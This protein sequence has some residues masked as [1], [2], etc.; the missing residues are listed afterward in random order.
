MKSDSELK[1]DVENELK[2]DPR[3]NQPHIG[4]SSKDGLITLSGH[5]T[6]YAEKSAAVKAANRVY[7]VKAV[8]DEIDVKLFGSP[9]HTDEDIAMACINALKSHYAVP[10]EKIKSYVGRRSRMEPPEAGCRVCYPAWN[11]RNHQ[12]NSNQATRLTRRH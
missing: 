9:N 5:V 10:D 2:W 6:A 4:V 7:G 8:A 1:R 3:V 11:P 12:Q